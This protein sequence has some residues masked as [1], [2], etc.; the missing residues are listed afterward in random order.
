MLCASA[1]AQETATEPS[2]IEVRHRGLEIEAN[3]DLASGLSM[4]AA[5]TYLD[6]EIVRDDPL[7]IGNRP[8]L[9]PE[10]QASLWANYE[11]G[12]GMLEGLS[13][14]AGVR[15]IGASF[16]DNANTVNVPGYTLVDAALRYKKNGWQAALNVSNL[17]DKTYYSTCYPGSGCI[18]GEGRVIK[19]SLSMKF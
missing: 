9:V 5:Y 1:F 19:G 4:T 13:V 7:V 6:A 18:Y 16:G 11:I 12:H 10:H 2:P 15:Y 17:F 14:G 3:A 8:S